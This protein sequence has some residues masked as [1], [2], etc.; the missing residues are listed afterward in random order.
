MGPFWVSFPFAF[1]PLVE[2]DIGLLGPFGT[3]VC[4]WVAP[5]YSS[6]FAIVG[7]LLCVEE[8]VEDATKER[9][10]IMGV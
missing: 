1:V 3:A 8:R 4:C 5:G 10:D 9:S 6:H 7:A 2:G